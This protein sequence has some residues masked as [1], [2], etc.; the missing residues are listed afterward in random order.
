MVAVAEPAAIPLIVRSYDVVDVMD[1]GLVIV[2]TL[3]FDD[4]V[5]MLYIELG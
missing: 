2:I 4:D 3:L 1:P 5:V